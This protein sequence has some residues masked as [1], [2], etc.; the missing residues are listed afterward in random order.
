[1]RLKTFSDLMVLTLAFCFHVPTESMLA[2]L[3]TE[4]WEQNDHFKHLHVKNTFFFAV[5]KAQA[6]LP[7]DPDSQVC[8]LG[9]R[10]IWVKTEDKPCSVPAPQRML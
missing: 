6:S 7:S 8:I 2:D 3:A 1:M 10:N 5:N 4:S 9:T